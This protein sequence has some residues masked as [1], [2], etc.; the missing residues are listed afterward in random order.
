LGL[1]IVRRNV[2]DLGGE[3]KIHSRKG[4]GTEFTIDLKCNEQSQEQAE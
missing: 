2:A 1:T 3:I 4:W